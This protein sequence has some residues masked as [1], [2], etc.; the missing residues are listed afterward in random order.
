MKIQWLISKL[1]NLNTRKIFRHRHDSIVNHK[2]KI[3]CLPDILLTNY[4]R[5]CAF[6]YFQIINDVTQAHIKFNFIVDDKTIGNIDIPMAKI[7]N[8]ELGE[9]R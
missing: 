6:H 1:C 8:P 2:K 9:L 7:V 5:L 4:E 3:A